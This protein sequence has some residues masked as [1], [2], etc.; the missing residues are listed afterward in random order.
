MIHSTK[1]AGALQ[2]AEDK[3]NEDLAER[4][5][6]GPWHGAGGMCTMLL[7]ERKEK[8][9]KQKIFN[10]FLFFRKTQIIQNA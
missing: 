3:I 9:K 4:F 7:T 10:E 6:W 2:S 5:A 1:K 8:Y